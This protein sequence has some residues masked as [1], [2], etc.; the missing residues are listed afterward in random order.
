M[1]F[2]DVKLPFC[3]AASA[4]RGLPLLAPDLPYTHPLRL[5]SQTHQ[6]FPPLDAQPVRTKEPA[7]NLLRLDLPRLF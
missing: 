7:V 1:S 4:V 6:R 5:T 3:L 2:P